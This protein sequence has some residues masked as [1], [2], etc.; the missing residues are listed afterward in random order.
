MQIKTQNTISKHQ[1][2]TLKIP[3]FTY[4]WPEECSP[5]AANVEAQM[6]S[7]AEK[8][9]LFPDLD[10]R[11]RV[12]RTRYGWLAARCYPRASLELLQAAADY[13]VWFFLA[14]DMFVDRVETFNRE[15][16][17][18]LTAMIDVIDF[19][20]ARPRP[21]YGELA[22]LDVCRRLRRLLPREA[23]SRFASGMRMWA[24]TAGL[25]MLLHLCDESSVDLRVYQTIRAHTSGMA[26][27]IA[28]AD[29][30][31][32]G[33]ISAQELYD[34][35][36]QTLVRLTGNVVCW[37]NDIHSVIVEARQPGQF[38]NSVIICARDVGS[39]QGG[40]DKMA[41]IVRGEIDRFIELS[42]VV[43]QRAGPELEGFIDGMRL[44]MKGYQNWADR[45][46]L[47]YDV[48]FADL[49]ADDRGRI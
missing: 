47:R 9:N 27:C 42:A 16:L 36:V 35:D 8:H 30:A 15:T 2:E 5:H 38:R 32:H 12:E 20:T 31:S 21:V 28:L 6:L 3:T 25:Q 44:W 10:Y 48:A 49:D 26:P 22:W 4:P 23:F 37:S 40:V 11:K 7:W 29:C 41:E 19:G 33:F 14:D 45:D 46:T 39:L 13:F 34:P 17:G 24:S 1:L 18:N 43:S